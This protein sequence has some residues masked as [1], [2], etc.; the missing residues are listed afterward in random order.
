[1]TKLFIA[2]VLTVAALTIAGSWAFA[3]E[4]PAWAK[5]GTVT[6]TDK[7]GKTSTVKAEDYKIVPRVQ[8]P[9]AKP[10]TRKNRLGLHAGQGPLGIKSSRA[11]GKLTIEQ[12][13]VFILGLSYARKIAPDLSLGAT[14][15]SNNTFT[16]DIGVDF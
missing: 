11:N 3:E 14:A 8:S 6:F 9:K 12:D 16:L 4:M 5:G 1:M 7:N 2:M 10:V 15:L 13:Y